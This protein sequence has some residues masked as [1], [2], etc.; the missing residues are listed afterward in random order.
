[1][2]N[3]IIRY[4]WEAEVK[5]A[6]RDAELSHLYGADVKNLWRYTSASPTLW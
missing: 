6:E 5:Q 3:G 2:T 4:K 1:M